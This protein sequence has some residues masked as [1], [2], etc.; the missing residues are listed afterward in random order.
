MKTVC[1]KTE[2][3]QY[4]ILIGHGLI[5]QLGGYCNQLSLG[6]KVAIIV[7]ERVERLYAESISKSLRLAGFEVLKVVCSGGENNKNLGGLEAIFG[8]LIGSEMD[9]TAWVVALGGGIIGDMAGFVAASY[10][11]GV[12]YIQVPTT[13]VAQVDSSIGGKTGVNHALGK[14]LIGAFHQPQLVFIDTDTLRSLPQGEVASGMAEVVKHAVIRD[15]EL[16]EFL[17][18]EL[19][20][21]I[22]MQVTA[23]QLDWLI[24]RNARIKAEVVSIDE[25][26]SGLRA[27]LNYGHTIGHAIEAA[28]NYEKYRH[29]EAVILGSLAVAHISESRGLMPAGE[30][31][32][33]DSLWERLGVPK[34]LKDVDSREILLRT[35][36]DKKRV[37]GDVRYILAEA[38]G[39]VDIYKDVSEK[40]VLNAI[41]YLQET[42]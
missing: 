4:R 42:Y 35:R 37:G 11:R 21:V 3:T 17:E 39:Q 15:P 29:G 20:N 32:R 2:G 13:I 40:D 31:L 1:V 38:V 16:F 18:R 23:S 9:R 5:D 8:Q 25:R 22:T 36:N 14:N 10:L 7:D 27:I 30:R 6:R 33:H 41:E 34:G 19:E 28:T 26:E 24:E 12:A